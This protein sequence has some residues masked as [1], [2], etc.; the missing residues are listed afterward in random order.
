MSKAD[1]AAAEAVRDFL[2]AAA[3]QLTVVGLVRTGDAMRDGDLAVFFRNNHFATLHKRGSALHTL[4]TDAGYARES[5]VVWESLDNVEGDTTF[6]TGDFVP[7]AEHQR[8][9]AEQD[10]RDHEA[11]MRQVEDAERR[12]QQLREQVRNVWLHVTFGYTLLTSV[13]RSVCYACY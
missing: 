11:V 10:A 12:E 1:V 9:V 7:Y 6:C 5:T 8:R 2:A 4:V 3:S 13:S